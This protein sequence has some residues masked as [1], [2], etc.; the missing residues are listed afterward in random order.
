MMDEKIEAVARALCKLDGLNPDQRTPGQR[1]AGFQIP[2]GDPPDDGPPLWECYKA[3]A[4]RFVVASDAL[5]PLLNR[6]NL[7]HW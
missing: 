6:S 4:E 7:V 3:E 5:A 1:A 2:A